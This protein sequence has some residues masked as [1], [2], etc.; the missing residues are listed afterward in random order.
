LGN[1]SLAFTVSKPA[2]WM[3][4]SLDGQDNATISGNITITDLTNGLHN[5]TTYAR[6]EFD[7]TG[8]SETIIFTVDVPEP[9]P[10]VPVAAASVASAGIIAVG[11]LLYFKKRKR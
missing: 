1:V 8:A 11:L 7:N 6:D 9:F 10:V 5:V 4:Y 2:L 3:G